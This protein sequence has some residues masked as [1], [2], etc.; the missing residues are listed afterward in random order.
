MRLSLPTGCRTVSTWYKIT[1]VRPLRPCVN[2]ISTETILEAVSEPLR[3]HWKA[4]RQSTSSGYPSPTQVLRTTEISSACKLKR[5]LKLVQF[6]LTTLNKITYILI[7]EPLS[8]RRSCGLVV[9]FFLWECPVA[10]NV[11]EVPGSKSS[12][13]P[14]RPYIFRTPR[15]HTDSRQGTVTMTVQVVSHPLT[16]RQK[17]T[18]CSI[19]SLVE[20]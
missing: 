8:T 12:S 9:R 17:K 2:D 10:L 15:M 7:S 18:G 14:A 11:E 20:T 19:L 1:N 6:S 3:S 16:G 4:R 13:T 5:E